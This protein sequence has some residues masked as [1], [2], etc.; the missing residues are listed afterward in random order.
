MG[1]R[2]GWVGLGGVL[3]EKDVNLRCIPCVSDTSFVYY[4]NQ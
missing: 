2:L 4:D 1:V 3:D